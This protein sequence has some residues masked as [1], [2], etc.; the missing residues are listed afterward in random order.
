MVMATIFVSIP[1]V[2]RAVAPVLEEIGDDQ[3]QAARTLGAG[4]VQTFRRI[5]L[6]VHP[7]RPRLRRRAR[8]GPVA[9]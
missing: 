7:G 2:V 3:E 6:P 1:L 8:R 5:T 9:R 4:P